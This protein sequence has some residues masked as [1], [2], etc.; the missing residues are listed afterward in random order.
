MAEQR[1]YNEE[2]KQR[3]LSSGE[4]PPDMNPALRTFNN[5]MIGV[6]RAV[7]DI[8]SLMGMIK[9]ALDTA[10][11]N[12]GSSLGLTQDTDFPTEM[13]GE[14]GMKQFAD[15]VGQKVQQEVAKLPPERQT[16]A[17]IEAI[18]N[19]YATTNEARDMLIEAGP[20]LTKWGMKAGN[21][22]NDTLG[23]GRI[24][25]ETITDDVGQIVGG[26]IVTRGALSPS[27]VG[28]KGLTRAAT[29]AV[30][31]SVAR[32]AG[33]RAVELALPLS[34]GTPGNIAANIGVGVAGSQGL[35]ALTD[36]PSVFTGDALAADAGVDAAYD[37]E[38]VDPE[39]GMN[40]EQMGALASAAGAA[41]VAAAVMTG[42]VNKIA[43]KKIIDEIDNPP[44]PKDELTPT[45]TG[46][47][48]AKSEFVDQS[49]PL[50][51][52]ITN[53][54]G[55]K[56]S[57]ALRE[58]ISDVERVTTN[59]ANV[60]LNTMH[61]NAVE[62]GM[63]PLGGG[64]TVELGKLDRLLAQ[65]PVDELQMFEQTMVAKTLLDKHALKLR[66][67]DE[68][69]RAAKLGLGGEGSDYRKY[70]AIKAEREAMGADDATLLGDLTVKQAKELSSQM[71]LNPR[72]SA[73]EMQLRKFSDD[74]INDKVRR[75][76]ITTEVA[77]RL[78]KSHPHHMMLQE[79]PLADKGT[80][81]KWWDMLKHQASGQSQPSLFGN[82]R[83]PLLARDAVEEVKK[84]KPVM[85]SFKQ[86][87]YDHI[88]YGV[89]NDATR[90][91]VNA[92]KQTPDW[93]RTI[94]EVAS[95]P[96]EEFHAT[97]ENKKVKGRDDI[98]AY[99][100]NG[101]I[102]YIEAADK[103]LLRAL[104]YNAPATMVVGNMMRKLYQQ[105]TTGIASPEFAPTAALF[106]DKIARMTRQ[107][108]RS[109]GI[110][111]AVLRRAFPN[112]KL[113]SDTLDKLGGTPLPMVNTSHIQMVAGLFQQIRYNELRNAAVKIATDLETQSGFFN[114]MAKLPGGKEVLQTASEAMLR[115]FNESRYAVFVN[116]GV[117]QSNLLDDP[118]RE[119]RAGF[120]AADYAMRGATAPIRH[121]FKQYTSML[122]MVHNSSK[123][124]FFAQNLA[125]LER[126]YKGG[127]VPQREIDK[128]VGEVKSLSGDMTRSVGNQTFGKIL[129]AVPYG[130]VAVNSTYHLGS[131]IKRDPVNVGARILTGD[132]MPKMAAISFISS[133]PALADWY[134]N[135]IP[136]WQRMSKVPIIGP[137]WWLDL[138]NGK[139][140]ELT[141][142][143][144]YMMPEAPEMTFISNP[145]ITF[146][147]TMGAFGGAATE[148]AD[149]LKELGEGMEGITSIAT[150]PLVSALASGAKID[151]G[152]VITSPLTG[153]AVVEENY[154]ENPHQGFNTT[155]IN[156]D[157]DISRSMSNMIGALFGVATQ[158][159]TNSVDIGVQSVENGDSFAKAF[160]K[161]FKYGAY[162]Q[163]RR[164]AEIPGTREAGAYLFTNGQRRRYASTQQRERIVALT[165]RFEPVKRQLSS[166][167][168]KSGANARAEAQGL[169][170]LAKI[171]DP[172]VRNLAQFMYDMLEKGKMRSLRDDRVD[173]NKDLAILEANK[174]RVSPRTYHENHTAIME[175]MNAVNA[176]QE[177][178]I[179]MLETALHRQ[180]QIDIDGAIE[181]IEMSIGR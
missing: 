15:F 46:P 101:K 86:Y 66:T 179:D 156:A 100:E 77:D 97:G 105:G 52:T 127:K 142:N 72:L 178:Q 113:L 55:G 76:E 13:Y 172:M 17:N 88:Q 53:A 173:L 5:V 11:Y 146:L 32:R 167:N 102:H 106:E 159:L 114:L 111:D 128:L 138:A 71:A 130:Q 160:E 35:R 118:L 135:E 38:P 54:Y 103:E 51:D 126:K 42:R 93:G 131:A 95:M 180:Y 73:I 112:S 47:Q 133:I 14:A 3:V 26:A 60:N 121:A 57:R 6:P 41:V 69:L 110:G 37:A 67:K 62:F 45:L 92:I 154:N 116:N 144:I 175:Q 2:Q 117:K 171:Q 164:L 59:T 78:R 68:E 168:D 157:S 8:G 109:Y 25:D 84:P 140:R 181:Q 16:Q 23:L 147:R 80:V 40:G 82:V 170:G 89:M 74:L 50:R 143:D 1:R 24:E 177:D 7:T 115:S 39:A 34:T 166:E 65:L 20:T 87:L 99:T 120:S 136:A 22:I 49:S 107:P 162:Q 9:P 98:F 44:G 70:H 21:A 43:A 161:A 64:K 29:K 19:H 158:N 96:I 81:G 124:A 91:Y 61:R 169:D 123:Y 163:E 176:Q 12:V 151:F 90:T 28:V 165:E 85:A 48:R 56:E 94:R 83:G 141:P 137:D 134:W 125:A 150:P 129:S 174:E 79:D 18:S 63:L 4:K 10:V 27:Q 30:E 155:G 122:E 33:A 108:G 119:T 58:A 31:G 148:H 75:G 132:I 104:Q 36:A 152:R 149:F 139:Q 153:K 145:M